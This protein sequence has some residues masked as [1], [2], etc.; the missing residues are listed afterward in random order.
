MTRPVAILLAV[1]L[2]GLVVAIVATEQ[3]VGDRGGDMSM[4]VLNLVAQ[5]LFAA[6]MVAYCGFA[7]LH[8][9]QH[10]DSPGDRSMWLIVTVAGNVLGSCWYYLSTYQRFRST[11]QGGLMRFRGSKNA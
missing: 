9:T 4:L 8:S 1:L 2:V 11:G 6:G 3:S 7:A 10:I 5:V